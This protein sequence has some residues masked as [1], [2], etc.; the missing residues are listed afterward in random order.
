MVKVANIKAE[1]EHAALIIQTRT[2]G[3]LH[4]AKAQKRAEEIR[5]IMAS[6]RIQTVWRGRKVGL[7]L[8]LGSGLGSRRCGEAER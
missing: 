3:N 4:R 6:K 7:G 5:Q 8:G 2:R 1:R